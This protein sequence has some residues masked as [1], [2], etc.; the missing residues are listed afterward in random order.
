M[1]EVKKESEII[2]T[3]ENS[4]GQETPVELVSDIELKRHYLVESIL[5]D[6][7]DY[8]KTGELL[9]RKIDERINYYLN[10]IGK[11]SKIKDGKDILGNISLTNYSQTK[12][13]KIA[14]NDVISFDE[15][16][17]IAKKKIDNCLKRWSEESGS[18]EQAKF[19]SAIAMEA[20][21]VDK[22]GSINKNSILRLLKVNI[23]DKEWVQAQIL[24][25]ESMQVSS[26]KKYKNYRIKAD[27]KAQWETINLNFN[28]F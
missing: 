15:R 21:N 19:L 14:I 23:K 16:L 22:K 9:S 4:R 5:A 8:K 25:K 24:I 7:L 26:T 17:N 27:P 18:Q 2:E 12:Q 6:V 3:I 1:D 11:K 13:V 28:T 20:F 10:W